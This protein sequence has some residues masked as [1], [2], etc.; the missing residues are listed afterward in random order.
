[1]RRLFVI[2]FYTLWT[3]NVLADSNQNPCLIHQCLAVVDAG[4]TGSRVHVYSYDLNE[5]QY[6]TQI[7][8]I[9][10]KKIQPGFA[11]VKAT[12]N[13]VAH[14]LNHLLIDAPV[15]EIPIYFYATAG[16]RLLPD[17]QQLALFKLLQDWFEKQKKWQLKEAKTIS[18][19][20][21]GVYGWLAVNHQLNAFNTNKPVGFMDMGGASVQIAFPVENTQGI[22][23]S[24]FV[25][26]D[27][28]DHHYALFVRSFLGLGQ[29]E[30]MKRFEYSA[31]CY[32][33]GYL[34]S[35][36]DI[37]Q[38]DAATCVE[39]I[40][41]F[42][43]AS[44]VDQVQPILENNQVTQWYTIGGLNM[45]ATTTLFHFDELQMTSELFID[46][47]DKAICH[48]SWQDVEKAEPTNDRNYAFCLNSS[49]YY[50]L[51]VHGY[52]IK[53]AKPIHFMPQQ[54][55]ADWSLGVL[56]AKK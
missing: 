56:L 38:G 39:D 54:Q 15:S 2:L 31:S 4:S 34:M 55:N 10:Y 9:W 52:G 3:F 21:E 44:G 30:V 45:L 48:S 24:D 25:E 36:G 17:D 22:N 53:P 41:Q 19:R 32:S 50:A 5:H 28:N 8:E 13:D 12:K 51:L 27:V 1:M 46:Q 35:N 37:G 49:Y 40:A 11:Q 42:I 16:M 7:H 47:A 43:T 18:G 14:Y 20:D 29:T 33:L 23:G 6:P 26:M